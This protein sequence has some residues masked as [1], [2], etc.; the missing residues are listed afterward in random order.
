LASLIDNVGSI[1]NSGLEL[2]ISGDP[3]VGDFHWNSSL[4]ISAN[5]NKVLELGN[6]ERMGFGTTK[7]G[8]GITAPFM[9][10]VEGEPFGQMYGWGTEGTWNESEAEQAAKY[11]QLPGDIKYTDVDKNGIIDVKDFKVIGNAF[12][13]FIFGWSNRISYNG[14]ELIFLVQGT[15]GNDIF[16]QSRIRLEGPFDGSSI[17]LLDRWT[18]Q[19]QDTD[20]PAFIDQ[21]TRQNANLTSTILAPDQRLSRWV[22]DGSY[23]RLKNVTLAYNFPKIITEK[24]KIGSLRTYISGTNLITLTKYTGFDPEVS[25]FTGNDAQFGVDFGNYPS[26][27][28]FTF[29]IDISF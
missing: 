13:D 16:N 7:G 24:I 28:T 22:E 5:R 20:V 27:Q 19:N 21:L 29:G 23:L 2:S 15:K 25:A 14:F 18:P 8:Q 3:I 26:A 4:N 6:I 1:G 9:Y 11:G 10:L 17:R 12:P